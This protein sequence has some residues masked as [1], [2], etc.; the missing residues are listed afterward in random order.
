MR[1]IAKTFKR[2]AVTFD[3]EPQAQA[4]ARKLVSELRFRG[5]DAFLVEGIQDDPGKMKQSEADYLVKQ[6]LKT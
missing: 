3:F 1:L 4:Q 6:I 2:V 5:R